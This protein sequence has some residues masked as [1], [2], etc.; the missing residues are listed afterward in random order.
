MHVN[1]PSPP[2]KEKM[3]RI[4]NICNPANCACDIINI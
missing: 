1:P 2:P 3:A 4:S